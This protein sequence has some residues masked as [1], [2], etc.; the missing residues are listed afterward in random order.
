MELERLE[1]RVAAAKA[2]LQVVQPPLMTGRS[3]VTHKFSF[4][5]S[6]DSGSFAFDFYD[7]VGE[8]ELLKS[9]IKKFDTGAVVQVVCLKG[10]PSPEAELLARDL[11]IRVL[12]PE[13]LIRSFEQLLIE[14][15]AE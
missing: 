2:G 6:D 1:L 12:S 15:T 3:G 7:T 8:I 14:T 5:A 10:I 4:L 11:E 9:A 13:S